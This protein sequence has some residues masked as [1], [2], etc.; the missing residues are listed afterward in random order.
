MNRPQHRPGDIVGVNLVAAHHQQ[1]RAL[2]R[3]GFATAVGQ[4]TADRLPPD[5]AACGRSRAATDRSANARQG[6]D[7]QR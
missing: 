6:S 3:I 5:D 7:N 1:G 2:L 4:R